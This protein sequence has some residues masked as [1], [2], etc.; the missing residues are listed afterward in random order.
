[1]AAQAT[2]VEKILKANAAMF[3]QRSMLALSPAHRQHGDEPGCH[4]GE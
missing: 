1:V 4:Q 2:A 3:L